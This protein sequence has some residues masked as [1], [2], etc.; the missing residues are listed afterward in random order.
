MTPLRSGAPLPLAR[1]VAH[2]GGHTACPV[3]LRQLKGQRTA[4]AELLAAFEATQRLF[5][6]GYA[7]LM[8]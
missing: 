4:Y 7:N 6:R 1:P 8:R 3:E 5:E 2:S